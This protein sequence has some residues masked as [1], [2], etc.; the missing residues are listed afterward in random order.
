MEGMGFEFFLGVR[1]K[2]I[3]GEQGRANGLLLEDGRFIDADLILISAGVRPHL[4]LA[5]ELGLE[6]GRGI[7][8]NDR[9]ECAVPNI[10]AAGDAIEHRG[11]YYGI[12]PAAEEQGRVAGLNMAGADAQ[13]QGTVVSNKLKVVGIDLVSAGEIDPDGQLESETVSDRSGGQYRKV[14]YRDDHI[15]GCVLLGDIGGQRRILKAIEHRTRL[16]DLK[17][18]VLKAPDAISVD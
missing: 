9:M 5:Q 1:S 3:Q 12:W 16:G 10:Y 18:R 6:I 17:G 15:V 14:V 4:E 7:V 13:Y 8:V 2:E 11:V